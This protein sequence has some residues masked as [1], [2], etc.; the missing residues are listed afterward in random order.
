MSSPGSHHAGD[1]V[2]RPPELIA[3]IAFQHAYE[4]EQ[5]MEREGQL[6]MLAEILSALHRQA[7]AID[8]LTVQLARLTDHVQSW[9]PAPTKGA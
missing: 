5:R 2:Y 3:S 9:L 1:G 6:Y 4:R 8:A 7:E